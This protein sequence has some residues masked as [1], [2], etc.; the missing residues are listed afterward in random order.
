MRVL[1]TVKNANAGNRKYK[2]EGLN[3]TGNICLIALLR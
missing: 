3:M 1:D 2:N